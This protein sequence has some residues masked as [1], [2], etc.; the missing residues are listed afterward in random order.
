ML[1]AVNKSK[2]CSDVMDIS[3][4]NCAG[5]SLRKQS[6]PGRWVM[7]GLHHKR[8]SFLRGNQNKNLQYLGDACETQR[9]YDF[10]KLSSLEYDIA[11]APCS[12]TLSWKRWSMRWSISDLVA[13]MDERYPEWDW[14]IPPLEPSCTRGPHLLITTAIQHSSL[15]RTFLAQRNTFQE[16]YG[17]RSNEP[18]QLS[19]D[20][21]GAC[22]FRL[23]CGFQNPADLGIRDAYIES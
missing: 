18:S 4:V 7:G 23:E 12:W 10:R 13:H 16:Q 15:S 9:V 11:I 17:R 14:A 1:K 5:C 8:A 6:Y 21:I 3:G 2:M 22:W 20:Y 19:T